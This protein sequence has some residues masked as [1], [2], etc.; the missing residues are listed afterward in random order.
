MDIKEAKTIVQKTIT[1]YPINLI[2][3]IGDSWAF[4]FDTGEPAVPGI[5][6][7]CINKHNGKT[8]YLTIP[9]LENLNMI[10]NGIPLP[11]DNV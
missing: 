4:G 9:P 10:H 6:F 7:V 5:P 8:S 1:D 2:V 11:L 3:D